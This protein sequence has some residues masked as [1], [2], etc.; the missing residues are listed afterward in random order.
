MPRSYPVEFRH[1]LLDLIETG[2]PVLE[3]AEK[4]ASGPLIRT[5]GRLA[6]PV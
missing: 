4:L 2:E 1:T 3:L 6:T 5:S